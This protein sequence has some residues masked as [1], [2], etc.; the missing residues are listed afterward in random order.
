M[1]K[2]TYA[3]IAKITAVDSLWLNTQTAPVDV[4]NLDNC[5][6]KLNLKVISVMCSSNETTYFKIN[7]GIFPNK[8]YQ[9]R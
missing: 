5:T 1:G 4:I 9:N 6:I 7:L 3:A 2:S 8:F